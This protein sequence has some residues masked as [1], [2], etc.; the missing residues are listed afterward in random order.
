MPGTLT[1]AEFSDKFTAFSNS[2]ICIP[3][4]TQTVQTDALFPEEEEGSNN[5]MVEDTQN[6]EFV[7]ETPHTQMPHTQLLTS[8]PNV[9]SQGN[10]VNM[11][12]AGASNKRPDSHDDSEVE[13]VSST[14]S[15]RNI[16]F[17]HVITEG[18]YS[19]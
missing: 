11:P 2:T 14:P 16:S 13:E 7:P 1:D 6:S 15:L 9:L 18:I 12:Q 17:S 8:T 5:L 3:E 19:L 10:A 4:D